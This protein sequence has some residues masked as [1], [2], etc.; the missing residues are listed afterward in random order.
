MKRLMS[1][2]LAAV[3]ALSL[4]ACGKTDNGGSADQSI[5]L[6]EFYNTL[7]QGDDA[8]AMEELPEDMLEDTYP[9]LTAIER[10]QTVAYAAMISAVAAEVAMVEVANADDAETVKNI[11]QARIDYMVGDGNGPGGAWY[12][13]AMDTWESQSRVV[14]SGNYVMMVVN[15]SCDSIVS[16]FKALF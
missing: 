15:G 8:P 7:Y 2:M 3:L 5:D 10:K 4:A 6:K 13:E 12:P 11:F 9:G 16:D 14:S 1:V